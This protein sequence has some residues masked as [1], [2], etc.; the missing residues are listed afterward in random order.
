MSASIQK[1]FVKI[2]IFILKIV[3][4][5]P[6]TPGG[7]FFRASAEHFLQNN[8]F[9]SKN[10]NKHY[11]LGQDVLSIILVSFHT[12]CFLS[13]NICEISQFFGKYFLFTCHFVGYFI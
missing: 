8:L 5:F 13:K 12:A 1:I 9:A 6:T 7:V 11:C 3:F 2:I 10:R 4:S